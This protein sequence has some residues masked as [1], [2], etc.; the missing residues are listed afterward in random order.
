[1]DS[2]NRGV[3]APSIRSS[4]M[5]TFRHVPLFSPPSVLTGNRS[6]PVPTFLDFS[7]LFFPRF[8]PLPEV[9][10]SSGTRQPR[11]DIPCRGLDASLSPLECGVLM[12]RPFYVLLP[13]SRGGFYTSLDAFVRTILSRHFRKFISFF[14]WLPLVSFLLIPPASAFLFFD[15]AC[16]GLV[17][18]ASPPSLVPPRRNPICGGFKVMTCVPP[19][20][21]SLQSMDP[22]LVMTPQSSF[23]FPPLFLFFSTAAFGSKA[24]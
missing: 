10:S 23:S 15:E 24:F 18:G 11:P 3:L 6:S 16:L 13:P 8:Y 19:S 14:F 2:L 22:A 12:T 17:V 4:F 7:L 9:F 20:P 5:V 21:V 1:M